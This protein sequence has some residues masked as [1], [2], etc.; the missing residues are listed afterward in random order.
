MPAGG[1]YKQLEGTSMASTHVAGVAALARAVNPKLTGYR[2]KRILMSTAVNT[3]SLRGKTVT[4]SRVDA[5]RA[6]RKARRLKARS[7]P[8]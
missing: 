2:L 6:I 4:G 1:V 8:G 5:I 7:G 3:R